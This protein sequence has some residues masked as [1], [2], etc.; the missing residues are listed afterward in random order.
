MIGS[1]ESELT[2]IYT[3]PI[4]LPLPH[5]KCHAKFI[6]GFDGV[7]GIGQGFL[8]GVA[9]ALMPFQLILHIH[10]RDRQFKTPERKSG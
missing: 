10:L 4:N 8:R 1:A 7:S 2:L 6:I 5:V 3:I 9:S